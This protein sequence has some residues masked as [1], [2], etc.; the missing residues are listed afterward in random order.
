MSLNIL[1]QSL[2]IV[3]CSICLRR[4]RMDDTV[5]EEKTTSKWTPSWMVHIHRIEFIQIKQSV[6]NVQKYDKIGD[7]GCRNDSATYPEMFYG[8]LSQLGKNTFQAPMTQDASD[9]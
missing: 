6:S 5:T 7:N 1:I 8:N 9:L 3:L 2:N 4:L